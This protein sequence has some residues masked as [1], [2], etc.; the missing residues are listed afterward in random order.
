[1]KNMV[2]LDANILLEISLNRGNLQRVES[3][4]QSVDNAS[5]SM[6]SV[7]LLF[8]FGLKEGISST[9]LQGIAEG[10]YMHGLMPEDYVW[11]KLHCVDNDFEDALQV[12]IAL[13]SGCTE[14]VT[15]DKSLAK[16]YTRY[17]NIKLI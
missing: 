4:L 9:I 17:I 6:L 8:Y 11:A 2:F 7:H 3:Y 14:F 15:L 5:V 10:Y 1:M 16:N 13:R 12:S